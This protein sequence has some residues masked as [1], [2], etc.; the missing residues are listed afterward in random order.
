MT[1]SEE[2]VAW[3]WSVRAGDLPAA[4]TAAAGRHLLD[5]LGCG[6]AAARS[7]AAPYTRALLAGAAAGRS[8]VLGGAPPSVAPGTDVPETV[9]PETAALVNGTLVHALDFDDTHAGGLVHA[10]AAVLPAALAVG[11]DAGANGAAFTAAVVVGY[12]TVCRL[13]AAVRH[14]FHARGFHATGVCGAFSAALVAARLW[15]L[16]EGA[17]VRALGI[18]GSF[19]SGSLEFLA[20][21]S[22]TKQLHPGWSAQAG[23]TAARLAA[24]GASGPATII[25]GER[26]LF[27][28][29]TGVRVPAD[30]VTGALGVRWETTR[31]TVKPYPVCQ[32]SHASLDALGT[33][34]VA[35]DDIEEVVVEVPD[36]AVDVVCEPLA[37]KRAPRTPYEAKFSLPW[38]AAALL[39]DGAVGVDTFAPAQL[40]RADVRAMAARV[41]YRRV[42]ADGPAADAPGRV[43]VRDR[44]GG[45]RTGSVPCSAGGPARPLDP[46][47]LRRKLV[48][49]VG[50]SG[51]ADAL[52]AAVGGLT[53]AP[54]LGVLA[55]T[56]TAAGV[57]V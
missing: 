23:I 10:T 11:Q 41:G 13:G 28:A 7:D 14:G 15:G 32:L 34:E 43:H 18:A 57:P 6:F 37:G 38:C 22:A 45:V 46:A 19:A 50:D 54:D 51:R 36:D 25:E 2:L 4:V 35:P 21:G 42:P 5:G 12:E 56:L 26:G 31:I 49:T 8:T 39:I 33:L 40:G 24:A 3:A 1:T 29:F 27:A 55:A 20:D 16:D 53:V 52:A 47:A 17:A 30:A 9:A 44:R 48:G